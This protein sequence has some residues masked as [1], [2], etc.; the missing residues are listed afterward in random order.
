M[1]NSVDKEKNI[2]NQGIQVKSTR[3]RGGASELLFDAVESGR[4]SL[5]GWVY[6]QKAL[7]R[8]RRIGFT[9]MELGR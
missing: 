5:V 9:N 4:R 3:T 8:G 1:K 7:K 2:P 6:L